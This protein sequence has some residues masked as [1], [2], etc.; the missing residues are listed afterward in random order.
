MTRLLVVDPGAQW[1]QQRLAERFPEI[2]VDGGPTYDEAAAYLPDAEILVTMGLGLTPALLAELR[3]LRWLHCLLAG[4][5]HLVDTLA[6]RPDVVLTSTRGVHGPQM[7]EMALLH[8]LA[9]A[10]RLTEVMHNQQAHLWR[11]PVQSMLSGKTVT[12]V[13]LGTVGRALAPVLRALGM[14]VRGVSRGRGPVAGVDELYGRDRLT[15]AVREAD[16]VVVLLPGGPDTERMVDADVLAA[17]KPTAHLTALGRPSAID[18]GALL[19]ALREGR[20][21]GA[22]LDALPAE[23][24]AADDPFWDLPNVLLTPHLGGRSDRY[25][26]QALTVLEPNLRSWLADRPGELVNVVDRGEARISR[27]GRVPPAHDR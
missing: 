20:L 25:A 6:G 7:T 4:T 27:A 15:E 14:H 12:V 23:P 18:H 5:D 16:F 10:R 17:M 22:G 19:R 9:H 26:E 2:R 1:W 11:P 8:M 3:S 21:G 24:P 13:G